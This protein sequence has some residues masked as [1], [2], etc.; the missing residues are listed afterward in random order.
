MNRLQQRLRSEEGFTLIELLVVMIIIGN[1][2]AISV[3]QYPAF[4]G[5]AQDTKCGG[6]PAAVLDAEESF[7]VNNKV[8]RHDLFAHQD[9]RQRHRYGCRLGQYAGD[10]YH[11]LRISGQGQRRP[12][13]TQARV[14]MVSSTMPTTAGNGSAVT[15]PTA[16]ATANT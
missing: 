4:R 14:A 9:A 10:A 1:L 2:I 8:H 13:T 12:G 6:C 5:T 16:L 15:C 11:L 7:S 3:P